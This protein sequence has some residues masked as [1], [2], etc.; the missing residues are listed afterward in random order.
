MGAGLD[1]QRADMSKHDF[2][3]AEF[4]D[5]RAR[6]RRAIG[7]R[8]LDWLLVFHPV[9]IHWLTGS[10]AKSYQA[11]QCL[12]VAAED[13]PLVILT[14]ESERAEFEQESLVDDVRTWG[15]PEP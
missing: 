12:L 4:A 6:A 14:R 8:G 2:P 11:F 3:P 9:T 7:D 10:E 15:G 1:P 13:R 5:R